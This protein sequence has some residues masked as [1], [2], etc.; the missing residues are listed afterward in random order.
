MKNLW[1]VRG[2][3]VVCI[4]SFGLEPAWAADPVTAPATTTP[5]STP[6]LSTT[7]SAAATQ[8]AAG[9]PVCVSSADPNAADGN[10]MQ[11]NCAV[12]NNIK[13]SIMNSYPKTS[14]NYQALS[15]A[16]QD[17]E[18][19]WHSCISKHDLAANAC[20]D[21]LS[22]NLKSVTS[23]LGPA[24]AALSG[25]ASANGS[26]DNFSKIMDLANKGLTAFNGACGAAKGFCQSSCQGAVDSLKNMSNL[27]STD[28]CT[29]DPSCSGQLIAQRQGLLDAIKKESDDKNNTIS[30][31]GKAAMCKEKFAQLM[32]ASAAGIASMIAGMMQGNQCEQQ[33]AAAASTTVDCTDPSQAQTPTCLCQ[34][35]PRLQGCDNSLQ[36]T[37]SSTGGSTT[38]GNT[39]ANGGT[40]MGDNPNLALP[41]TAPDVSRDPSSA[42]ASSL[43]GGGGGAN[44]GG[45]SGLSGG[46]GG[47]GDGAA[48]KSLDTNILAG[49]SGGGGGGG[50]WGGGFGNSNS[51]EKYRSYLPGGS[52]D[53]KLGGNAWAS[54]VTGQG[55]K[56]NWEKVRDRYRDNKPTLINN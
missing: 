28:T 22:D 52:K 35:N 24:V 16:E 56:S 6:A 50:G 23:A 38:F 34:A 33:T 44:L 49:T 53:P 8:E 5:A 31:A 21:G 3:L 25:A 12:V 29:G 40:K 36:K 48:Q 20:L 54:E 15:S 4:L 47:S 26:C 9:D 39:A 18:K 13:D 51:D 11:A 2:L 27:V 17:F 37:G 30:S 1:K 45:G 19:K 7:P 43:P 46:G 41:P 32:A 10:K 55:G 42:S 14:K